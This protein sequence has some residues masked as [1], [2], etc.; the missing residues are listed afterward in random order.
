[1]ILMGLLSLV[2]S[3]REAGRKAHTFLDHQLVNGLEDTSC[4]RGAAFIAVI[5]P[6]LW[7]LRG[8]W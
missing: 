6:E 5:L 2:A 4:T 7:I 8:S 1:M 3:D